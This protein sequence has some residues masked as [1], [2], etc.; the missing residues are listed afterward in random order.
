MIWL[1]WEPTAEGAV[2]ITTQPSHINAYFSGNVMDCHVTARGSN[3]G[4][5]GVFIEL[6]V[7]RKGQ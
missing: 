3:P 2:N 6:H 4:R 5:N 7:L 1:G